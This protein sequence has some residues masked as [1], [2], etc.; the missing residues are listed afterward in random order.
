M[1]LDSKNLSLIG[2]LVAVIALITLFL[3]IASFEGAK[4]GI[5]GLDLI[6]GSKAGN[7]LASIGVKFNML[8][9]V[10]YLSLVGAAVLLA[11]NPKNGF[12]AGL[13]FI[14]AI[15][16]V[17]IGASSS[18]VF[19]NVPTVGEVIQNV[20]IHILIWGYMAA[21]LS[22][23]GAGASIQASLLTNKRSSKKR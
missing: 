16:G 7:D 15:A 11:F 17:L 8:A 21:V 14:V 22:L 4:E 12:I 6:F 3:P 5:T 1:K 23:V 13:L 2:I 18:K 10:G 20:D 9:L 19:L